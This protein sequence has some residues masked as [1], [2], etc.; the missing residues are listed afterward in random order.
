MTGPVATS[1]TPTALAVE[2][3]LR[4]L[5]KAQRALQLYLPNNP[6]RAHAI[7][8]TRAAFGR[9]WKFTPTIDL[10][11]NESSFVWEAHV[12]YRDIERGTE[13]LPWLLYRDG[14]RV[15]TLHAGFETA[16]LESLLNVFQR[17]RTT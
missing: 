6:T 5:A 16:D 1:P 14:L 17:A 10:D 13:G 11:I 12:V 8:N 7:E 4:A 15:L 9:V 3:A 2:D